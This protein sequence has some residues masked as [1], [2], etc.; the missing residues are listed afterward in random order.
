MPR[1]F[2]GRGYFISGGSNNMAESESYISYL[3]TEQAQAI[4]RLSQA[5]MDALRDYLGSHGFVEFLSPLISS[6]TDPGLR[7]AERL[8]VTLYNRKAYVTSSMVFHKQV[9]ATAFRRIY[10]FA[11]NVRLEPVENA[12]SGRHLV[13]FCQLDLEEADA[14]CDDSMALAEGMLAATISA[15]VEK[16]SPLLRALGRELQVPRLPFRRFTYSQMMDYAASLG[17]PVKYGDELPQAVESAVSCEVGGFFW[18]T[19]YPK[20]CR[21]FYYRESDESPGTVS[22]MDLIFPEGFGEAISGGEREYRPDSIRR[23]IKESGLDTGDFVEFLT[24]AESGLSPTSGFGIG[25]ERL[26]R[27]ISGEREISR[28]RPFPKLPGVVTM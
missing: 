18:I 26:V 20:S 5:V 3:Q 15:V 28:V 12:C 1:P 24:M 21:G 23:R 8:P 17:L 16:C 4:F 27:F 2:R 9:L 7:G 25:V 19:G 11:P 10:A 13:E 22:S 14:T 6:I